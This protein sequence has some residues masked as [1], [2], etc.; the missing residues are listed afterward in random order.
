MDRAQFGLATFHR[1]GFDLWAWVKLAR[2]LGLGGLEL[3]ADP[4]IA[5]PQD[6]S[7]EERGRLKSLSQDGLWLSMHMPIYGINLTSPN[8]RVA[9]ASLAEVME[10]LDL[11]QEIGAMTMVVHP[12]LLPQEYAPLEPWRGRAQEVL[13]FTL[14][15]I[16]SKAEAK[17][18]RVALENKQLS[19]EVEFVL[20]PRDHLA[21][22][23]EF[24]DLWACLDLGHLHTVGEEPGEYVRALGSRLLHFHL[25][26][27]RGKEDEH[28]PLGEGSAPWREALAA[29]E[30]IGFRGHVVLEI[31]DP[32]GLKKSLDM[33]FS[34]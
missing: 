25:H 20:T 15:L 22:L 28:L 19:K 34:P 16:L 14:S 18:V 29:L 32:L 10:A 8:P 26:D 23:G 31:P 11:A 3:R 6:L 27:N 24:P 33:I 4:G 5:H 9:A 17:G 30:E 13:R 12:G 2:A 1:P 21:L 7:R